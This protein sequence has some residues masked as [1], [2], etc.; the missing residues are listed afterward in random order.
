MA[1]VINRTLEIAAPAAIVWEVISDLPRYGEWNPFCVEVKST[2]RPGD[3][4]DMR[5]KLL[6]RPQFQREYVTEFIDGHGFTYRMKPVPGGALASR[7]SH[8]IEA[9]DAE[10]SRYES[11]FRLQGWLM[12]LVR[13]LLGRRLLAGFTGMNEGVKRR[14][15][16]L[17]AERR[18][19]A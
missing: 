7:R 5:V 10:H 16:M 4:I 13:A 8:A 3:T 14:A 17:W 15:E 19:T 11:R 2:L 1:F 9:L 12:P 18:R 6:A